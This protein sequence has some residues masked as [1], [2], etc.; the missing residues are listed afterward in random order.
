MKCVITL[1][2]FVDDDGNDAAASVQRS[3]KVRC[4]EKG[5]LSLSDTGPLRFYTAISQVSIDNKKNY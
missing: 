3:L 4:L 2:V 1:V 5:V